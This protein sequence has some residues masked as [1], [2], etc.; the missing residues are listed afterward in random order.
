MPHVYQ[1]HINCNFRTH[2]NDLPWVW[3]R[4][5]WKSCI[6]NRTRQSNNSA[7]I[8][9]YTKKILVRILIVKNFETTFFF[10]LC[11]WGEFSICKRT[12]SPSHNLTRKTTTI[13]QKKS[14]EDEHHSKKKYSERRI[15]TGKKWKS[16][17]RFFFSSA[18]L[19][20][21]NFLFKLP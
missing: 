15:K 8:N 21:E 16:T 17:P 12:S 2:S 19:A 10:S 3:I 1:L 18:T 20:I 9:K 7:S 14:N 13:E 5:Q 6:Y 4:R 11:L